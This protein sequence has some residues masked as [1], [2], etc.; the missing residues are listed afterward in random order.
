MFTIKYCLEKLKAFRGLFRQILNKS[1][2]PF[3]LF[4]FNMPSYFDIEIFYLL[5][6]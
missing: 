4:A 6:I 5:K 2:I 1:S 3:P